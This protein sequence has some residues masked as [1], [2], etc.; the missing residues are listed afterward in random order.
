MPVWRAES[1]GKY[2]KGVGEVEPLQ[3]PS[4]LLQVVDALLHVRRV[5][6]DALDLHRAR[7]RYREEEQIGRSVAQVF[8]P[9][10]R[11]KGGLNEG[12]DPR[13]Y[14]TL[15]GVGELRLLHSAIL[16]IKSRLATSYAKKS[17]INNI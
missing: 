7:P 17:Y 14:L 3:Q 6:D 15:A 4:D 12:V 11:S 1:G 2:F 9:G 8:D 13:E 5:L 16:N 10:D